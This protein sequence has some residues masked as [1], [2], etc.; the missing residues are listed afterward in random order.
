[1]GIEV[2]ALMASSAIIATVTIG[3]LGWAVDAHPL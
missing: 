2:V 3:A 1:M